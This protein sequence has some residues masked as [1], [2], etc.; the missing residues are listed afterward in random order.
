[1]T[2]I[3]YLL[4]ELLSNFPTLK[5]VQFLHPDRW[6]DS[7]ASNAIPDIAL[8]ICNILKKSLLMVLS[9]SDLVT[10]EDVSESEINGCYFK[11]GNFQNIGI[12]IQMTNNLYWAIKIPTGNV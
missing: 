1:M 8:K 6:N 10:K 5:H 11:T 7:V 2:A 12:E 9:G 3:S 4:E